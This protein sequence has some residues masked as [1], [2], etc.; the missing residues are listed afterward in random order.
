MRIVR[1]EGLATRRCAGRCGRL[2]VPS[3]YAGDAKSA[4]GRQSLCPECKG[5]RTKLGMWY[6]DYR[7]TEPLALRCLEAQDYTCPGC[8]GHIDPE[9]VPFHRWCGVAV[10]AHEVSGEV[11]WLRHS[12]CGK[13]QGRDWAWWRTSPPMRRANYGRPVYTRASGRGP[14]QLGLLPV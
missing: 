6:T 2:L 1:Q 5:E 7:L 12:G 14:E 8:D 9:W 11:L 3:Y 13:Q 10:E 4:D